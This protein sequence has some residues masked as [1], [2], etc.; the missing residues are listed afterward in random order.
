MRFH[1]AFFGNAVVMRVRDTVDDKLLFED[2]VALAY[3]NRT[4]GESRPMGFFTLFDGM[5]TVDVVSTAQDAADS[6]IRPGEVVIVVYQS[7]DSALW[8]SE[9]LVQRE[10]LEIAGLEFTFLREK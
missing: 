5:L 8:V 10:P 2:G 3:R 4:Y 7:G 9:K 1:Q 6:F